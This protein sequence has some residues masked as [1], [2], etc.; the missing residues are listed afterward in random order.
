MAPKNEG[1]DLGRL[2]LW[3][4]LPAPREDHDEPDHDDTC[5]PGCDCEKGV[6]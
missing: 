4:L 5:G 6:Q 2:C 1:P 3:G